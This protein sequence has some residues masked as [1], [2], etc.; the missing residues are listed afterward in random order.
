MFFIGYFGGEHKQIY[1][2]ILFLDVLE[3]VTLTE[4]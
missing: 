3:T 2:R 1:A 4:W